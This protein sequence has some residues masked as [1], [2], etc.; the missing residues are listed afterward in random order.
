[1]KRSKLNVADFSVAIPSS[2]TRPGTL[3]IDTLCDG[4]AGE[5]ARPLPCPADREGHAERPRAR[6]EDGEV[7]LG[8]VPPAEDVGVDRHDLREEL[9]EQRPLVGHEDDVARTSF[10]PSAGGSLPRTKTHSR[11][12]VASAAESSGPPSPSVSMSSARSVRS[13]FTSAVLM[14]GLSKNKTPRCSRAGP[15]MREPSR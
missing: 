2:T 6:V 4:T 15:S 3:A 9:H 11:F 7:E 1:M 8:D 5:D 13:P 12:A 14:R 10:A